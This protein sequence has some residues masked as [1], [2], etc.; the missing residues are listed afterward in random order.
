MS[1][2]KQRHGCLTTWLVLM[3]ILNSL[4]SALYF[5]GS[6]TLRQNYPSAPDW[7]ATVL[8]AMSIVNI[9][10]GIALFRWK[11]WGFF[12]FIAT[13]AVGFMINLII[14]LN[15]FQALLGL[16]GVAALYGVLQIGKENKG[17]TQLE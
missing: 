9:V 5:L 14:G 1:E 8:F 11:K 13:S 6:A 17:W 12:V 10:C 15:I 4:A 2:G 16:I 3:M 7:A